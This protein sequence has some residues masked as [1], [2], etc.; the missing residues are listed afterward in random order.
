[1]NQCKWCG[2][3]D[4]Y[5]WI[6]I[7]IVFI[8]L[9]LITNTF[10]LVWFG[11]GAFVSALLNYLGFDIYIQFA[12]FLIVSLVLI[13]STRKF[14]VRITKEPTKKATSERLIGM[15]ATVVKKLY[16]DKAI[17]EVKGEK[18]SAIIPEDIEVG[19]IVRI[20]SIDSIILVTEKI[21]KGD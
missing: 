18:W 1:M 6:L 10:F 19:E 3:M 21:D 14:A 8:F 12:A 9:E 7:A 13:L 5:I 15:Y 17:V 16:D 2:Y 11:I 4:I 20:S